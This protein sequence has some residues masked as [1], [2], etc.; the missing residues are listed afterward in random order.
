MPIVQHCGMLETRNS[1]GMNMRER[2]HEL[3]FSVL[4]TELTTRLYYSAYSESDSDNVANGSSA[5]ST[6][7][8]LILHTL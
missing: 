7:L 1:P 6:Q 5:F 4:R 2:D 3:D 8:N